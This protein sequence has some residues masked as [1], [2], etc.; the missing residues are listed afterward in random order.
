M[1][2]ISL[3]PFVSECFADH[4]VKGALIYPDIFSA[5]ALDFVPLHLRIIHLG[6]TIFMAAKDFPLTNFVIPPEFLFTGGTVDGKHG[7]NEWKVVWTF[8][9]GRYG[10]VLGGIGLA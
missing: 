7:D 6:D 5:Q 4:F 2:L 3:S 10:H 1:E 9:L 8:F